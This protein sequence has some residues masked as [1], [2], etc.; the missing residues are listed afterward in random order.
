MTASRI[1]RALAAFLAASVLASCGDDPGPGAAERDGRRGHAADGAGKSGE[2]AKA[3]KQTHRSKQSG[4][5][6][7]RAD[8]ATATSHQTGGRHA[9]PAGAGATGTDGDA[10]SQPQGAESASS[11]LSDRSGDLDSSG[12]APAYVDLTRG[13]VREQDGVVTVE[14]TSVGEL[15]DRTDDDNTH[16]SIGFELTPPSGSSTFV[17]AD[18][19]AG[20]WTAHLSRGNQQRELGDALTISGNR[21][22]IEF[23]PSEL[24]GARQLQWSVTSS[25]VESTL[26]S[27]SYAFDAAPDSGS[28]RFER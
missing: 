7:G 3:T 15:P 6:R 10:G 20:G 14:A 26:L 19:T 22:R 2:R 17:Y 4:D 25:W 24:G 28:A 13:C 27:T 9:E 23:A 18:A 5:Q 8:S 21:M 11:C 16:A 12:S 1:T